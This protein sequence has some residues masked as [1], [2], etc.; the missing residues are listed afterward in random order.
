VLYGE[1]EA[2]NIRIELEKL[3]S[4]KNFA[5]ADRLLRKYTYRMHDLSQFMK[6]LMQRVTM[7]YNK[8]H[9]RRGHL[10]EERF[11]SLLVEGHRNAL[12]MISAYIDLN[13]VRAGL[14]KDPKDYRYCGYG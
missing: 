2:K 7:S 11:K 5:M 12:S 1:S 8:R 9:D 10:W 13:A 6:S 14:V 4:E 3:R